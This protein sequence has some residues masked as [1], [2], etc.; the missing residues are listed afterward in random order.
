MSLKCVIIF[1]D[2]A[3]SDTSNAR[4]LQAQ[5]VFVETPLVANSFIE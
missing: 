1:I 2:G 5:A 3:A 4:L